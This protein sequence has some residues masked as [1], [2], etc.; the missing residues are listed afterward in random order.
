MT[1]DIAVERATE[2]IENLIRSESARP[3]LAR[4]FTTLQQ[5]PE[6]TPEPKPAKIDHTYLPLDALEEV[7]RSLMYGAEKGDAWRWARE[8]IGWTE[9]LAKAQRHLFEFQKG[10]DIDPTSGRQHLACA[11]TQLMFLQSY[12]ITGSGTDDRFKR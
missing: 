1:E 3:R 6:P 7:S 11:I 10:N 9:R 5:A 8:P 4:A 12:V 2:H